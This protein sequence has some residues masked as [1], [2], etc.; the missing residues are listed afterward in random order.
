M[1]IDAPALRTAGHVE[2]TEAEGP[3]RRFALWVQGCSL[4][5]PGCCNP[6]MFDAS[7][8]TVQPVHVWAERLA[9]ARDRHAVAGLTVVGGEPVQQAEAVGALCRH[10]RA[11]GLS[12]LVFTGFTLEQARTQPGFAGLLRH[13]DTLVD[14]PFDPRR[15]EPVSGRRF[16]GSVNQRVLH[17]T[18]R[19]ADP[20]LWRGSPCAEA[21]VGPDGSL[22]VVG[23][24]TEVRA[25]IRHL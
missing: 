19:H 24:P 3:G 14:G 23:F 6:E 8:G 4:R 20:S 12:T 16:V 11:L 18:L 17:R 21:I 7:G 5:C 1:R 25:L 22:R 2:C 10:A 9:R 15:R 13:V